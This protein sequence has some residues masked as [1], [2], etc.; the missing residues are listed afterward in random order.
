MTKTRYQEAAQRILAVY[1]P[2]LLELQPRYEE[3]VFSGL[4]AFLGIQN[5]LWPLWI[6]LCDKIGHPIN[7]TEKLH[8][9]TDPDL[10]QL[11]W[12]CATNPFTADA[13]WMLVRGSGLPDSATVFP[14]LM[15]SDM[16]STLLTLNQQE[17]TIFYGQ[18][19][20]VFGRWG[21]YTDRQKL[22]VFGTVR[23]FDELPSEGRSELHVPAVHCDR[24]LTDWPVWHK[25]S[26][27]VVDELQSFAKDC[28]MS[29]STS[30][31]EISLKLDFWHMVSA[32]WD[33]LLEEEI[34]HC[35]PFDTG[36]VPFWDIFR[37]KK[38]L[39]FHGF[40]VLFGDHHQLWQ[41]MHQR[42]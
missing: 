39:A 31:V 24:L 30:A 36:K 41:E 15:R 3:A 33:Q 29:R 10:H 13:A 7:E 5:G 12:F 28:G 6:H 35:A 4:V 11:P 32:M 22:D 21:L 42:H 27:S 18:A 8:L 26:L 1:K 17:P 37:A 14:E 40:M 16:C 20:E 38:T 19:A 2:S 9:L 25:A 34:I 23:D